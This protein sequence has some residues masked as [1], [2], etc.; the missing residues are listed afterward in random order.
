MWKL[1]VALYSLGW[2]GKQM[3]TKD[4]V[5]DSTDDVSLFKELVVSNSF[6]TSI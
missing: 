6:L 5:S 4:H 1:N 3:A 2:R